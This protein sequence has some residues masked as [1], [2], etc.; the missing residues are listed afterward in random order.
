MKYED[1][2][3]TEHWRTMRRLALEHADYRCQLCGSTDDLHVHHREYNPYNERLSDLTVLCGNCHARF[4]GVKR[5]WLLNLISDATKALEDAQKQGEEN[6]TN[7]V[8]V[9][10]RCVTALKLF[11]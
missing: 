3:K 9:L 8:R 4:H 7:L 1:Y 11:V 2:L 6:T 5:T 10:Q